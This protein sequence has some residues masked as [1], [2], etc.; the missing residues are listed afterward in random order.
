VY[1]RQGLLS[2]QWHREE[3]RETRYQG[4]GR[5]GANRATQVQVIVRYQIERVEREEEAITL[6]KARL[7]WRVQVTN[8]P[9][10]EHS[11]LQCV[12]T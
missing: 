4:R 8:W 2:V 1:K 5:G 11:L 6:A 9:K 3:N 10:K 12:L 7:G